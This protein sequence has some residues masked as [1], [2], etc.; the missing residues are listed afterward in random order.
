MVEITEDM[1]TIIKRAILSFA[2]TVNEDG[3]PNLSPKATL[4]VRNIS[5]YLADIAS[6]GTARNLR[7]NPAPRSS[8]DAVIALKAAQCFC[9]TATARIRLFP[10]GFGR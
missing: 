3:T 4:T 7:R 8:R 2:A 10:T 1:E 5:L 9:R 6:P